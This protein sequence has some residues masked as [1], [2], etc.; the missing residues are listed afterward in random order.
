VQR[1]CGDPRLL[2]CQNYAF[3]MENL[4]T[5]GKIKFPSIRRN[6][7]ACFERFREIL[8]T[9][10]KIIS[11]IIIGRNLIQRATAVFGIRF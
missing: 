5:R 6:C 2:P 7:A 3:D 9:C 10:V 11:Q 1:A 4:H 8:I